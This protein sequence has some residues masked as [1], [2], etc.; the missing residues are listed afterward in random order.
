[1]QYIC[2]IKCTYIDYY[3]HLWQIN[4]RY[5]KKR[6]I[7]AYAL[8]QKFVGKKNISNYNL[9]SDKDT[10]MLW[11]FRKGDIGKPMANYE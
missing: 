5:L 8:K 10:A 1:M 3:K 11:I 9:H 6:G 7:D 2:K 4:D